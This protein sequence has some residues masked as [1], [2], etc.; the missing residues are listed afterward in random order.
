MSIAGTNGLLYTF[1][2]CCNPVPGDSIIGYVTRGRGV[3]VHRLDCPNITHEPERLIA[4]SWGLV[5][6]EERYSVP[7]EVIAYD[8]EGLLRDIS[9]VIA[10]EQVNMS[11]VNVKTK[12]NIATLYLTMELADMRQLT[13]ILSRLENVDQVVEARRRH[14]S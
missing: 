1:A 5:D 8:R 14:I 13:R 10:D 6:K 7:V 4:V 12:H 9:T 3:S 11:E 2:R